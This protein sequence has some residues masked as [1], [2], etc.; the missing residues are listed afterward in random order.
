M[1]VCP[2]WGT[3]GRYS[4]EWCHGFARDVTSLGGRAVVVHWPGFEDSTGDPDDV[5]LAS[6]I[7]ACTDVAAHGWAMAGFGVGAAAVAVAAERLAS[8]YLVLVEPQLDPGAHFAALARSYRRV[9]L[10]QVDASRWVFGAPV[11]D[12]LRDDD[13]ASVREALAARTAHGGP[14]L[15][16]RSRDGLASRPTDGVTLVEVAGN[17]RGDRYL[18]RLPLRRLGEKWLRRELRRTPPTS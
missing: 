13:G 18:D 9:S 17:G 6:M 8:P 2:S 16:L 5:S 7:D 14:T 4:L 3:E 12:G 11:P 10:G 15:V 1:L